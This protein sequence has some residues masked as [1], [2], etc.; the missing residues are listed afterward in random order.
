MRDYL[1]DLVKHTHDPGFIDLIK[2]T[3]TDKKTEII[4]VADDLSVVLQG[5]F[6]NPV[7][8]FMGT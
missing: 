2:V 8:E 6:K 4:G 7:P 5:E 3:G 1:L